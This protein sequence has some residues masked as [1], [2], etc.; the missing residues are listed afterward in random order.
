MFLSPALD[1]G[2]RSSC[3]PF[4]S[5]GG[6]GGAIMSTDSTL[7]QNI[8]KLVDVDAQQGACAYP[9]SSQ[10]C[11]APTLCRP[12]HLSPGLPVHQANP[13]KTLSPSLCEMQQTP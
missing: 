9:H 3:I 5:C 8:K 4:K 7:V 12:L 2:W 1:S 11:T 10:Q 13:T 6:L